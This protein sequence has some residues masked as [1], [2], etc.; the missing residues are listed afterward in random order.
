MSGAAQQVATNDTDNPV[1][2][3]VL[4]DMESVLSFAQWSKGQAILL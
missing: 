4:P 3:R 1:P 2:Y